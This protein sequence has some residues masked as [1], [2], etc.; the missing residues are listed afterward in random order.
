MV[1]RDENLFDGGC[2]G[3]LAFLVIGSCVVEGDADRTF[4]DILSTNSIPTEGI[5]S[6]S[7]E[8]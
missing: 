3:W 4:L 7:Y 1:E 2:W 6:S 8:C 5:I